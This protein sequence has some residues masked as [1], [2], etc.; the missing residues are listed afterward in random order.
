M[1]EKNFTKNFNKALA[2]EIKIYLE[3]KKIKKNLAVYNEYSVKL[4]NGKTSK[5]DIAIVNK[6]DRGES[7]QPNKIV[8]IEIEFINSPKQIKLNYDK[9]K[10]YIEEKKTRKGSLLQLFSSNANI[11]DKKKDEILKS[12]LNDNKTIANFSYDMKEFIVEDERKSKEKA[13]VTFQS[14]KRIINQIIRKVHEVNY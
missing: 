12:A 5:L 8:G 4:S 9:F 1:A 11:S 2:E 14:C 10:I 6:N 3:S 13:K 7:E